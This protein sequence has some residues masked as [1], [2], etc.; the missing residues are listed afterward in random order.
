MKDSQNR[1]KAVTG[2][3]QH[4]A[5]SVD[6][7]DQVNDEHEPAESVTS[8]CGQT[9]DLISQTS[10]RDA[11]RGSPGKTRLTV[12]R[13]MNGRRM[14]FDGFACESVR[15]PLCDYCG[16]ND[17]LFGRPTLKPAPL[18][19]CRTCAAA[20]TS[21]GRPLCLRCITK[22]IGLP[23]DPHQADHLL[24]EW[25]QAQEFV[26]SKL[27]RGRSS[28]I[29]HAPDAQN[30]E[31]WSSWLQG[32]LCFD[33][34]ASGHLN[35]RWVL[36]AAPGTYTLSVQ[37]RTTKCE[38]R[39]RSSA[40]GHRTSAL[41]KTKAVRLGSILVG[42]Q[43]LGHAEMSRQEERSSRQHLP[44]GAIEYKVKLADDQIET[45]TIEHEVRQSDD[46]TGKS[47]LSI[48]NGQCLV[49]YVHASY[50][51]NDFKAGS[52]FKFWLERIR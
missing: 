38:D 3:V 28:I 37:V 40:I 51:V 8:S 25:K 31:Y 22:L 7:D 18:Y 41:V 20:A 33:P 39:I 48:T 34:P 10:Q 44:E 52:P 47:I 46:K 23:S 30:P 4:V 17:R 9:K 14:D 32:D 24:R 42:A 50:D 35:T 19:Y 43:V 45:Y 11:K 16:Q 21:E 2:R 5:P 29:V 15:T 6:E 36:R 13:S 27:L 1:P 12:T 49:L 26:P